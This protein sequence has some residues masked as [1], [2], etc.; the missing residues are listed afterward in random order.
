MMKLLGTHWLTKLCRGPVWGEEAFC[1]APQGKIKHC[2]CDCWVPL[3]FL[4]LVN[5]CSSGT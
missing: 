1:A 2:V 3:G 5:M 4:V